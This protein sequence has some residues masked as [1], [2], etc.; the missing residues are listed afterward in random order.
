MKVAH[1]ATSLHGGAGIAAYRI[2]ESLI[3]SGVDSTIF[4][5]SAPAEYQNKPGVTVIKRN[6]TKRNLSSAVTAFQSFAV[7]KT[8]NLFTPF[9]IHQSSLKEII[10]SNFDILHL[11][12]TYNLSNWRELNCHIG[13]ASLVIT[14]HDMRNFTGGCHHSNDCQK[15]INQNCSNCPQAKLGFKQIVQSSFQKSVKRTNEFARVS[16]VAPS[17]WIL[18]KARDGLMWKNREISLIRN[19]IPDLE[20]YIKPV[21]K[22]SR[23]KI[24]FISPELANPFKGIDVLIAALR[25]LPQ[26]WWKSNEVIIVGNGMVP[27]F[28]PPAKITRL[29]KMSPKKLVDIYDELDYLVIPSRQD[30]FPNVIGEAT[31]RGV[32]LILSSAGGLNEA[33]Q[34][35]D[36]PKFQSGDSDNLVKCLLNLQK[37]ERGLVVERAKEIFCY[38]RAAT[39][40]KKL[41]TSLK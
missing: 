35:F 36:F 34:I 32:N 33:A 15:Y 14:L 41:Y 21:Q 16:L 26:D 11:H 17:Q 23:N 38:A 37:I 7:Q 18:D 31:L 1:L 28:G 22:G 39:A 30:N 12:N 24:G 9:S 10:D 40:Y 25:K 6:F 4:A 3:L 8:E 27:E 20:D 29:E 5:L 19:P 13:R 2:H